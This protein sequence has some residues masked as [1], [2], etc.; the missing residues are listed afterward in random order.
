MELTRKYGLPKLSWRRIAEI[1]G[2]KR[3]RLTRYGPTLN[4]VFEYQFKDSKEAYCM[5]LDRKEISD[6]DDLEYCKEYGY[7]DAEN[8]IFRVFNDDETT[9]GQ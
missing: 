9:S 5:S 2:V 3:T 6:L 7:Y 8:K 1:L 4:N